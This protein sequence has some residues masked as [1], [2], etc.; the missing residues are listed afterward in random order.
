MIEITDP[1]DPRIEPYRDLRWRE[2]VNGFIAEGPY[3]VER[4]LESSLA[5]R[6]LLFLKGQESRFSHLLPASTPVYTVDRRLGKQIAGYDFHRGVLAHGDVP[7]MLDC[8][9]LRAR[10]PKV[11]LGLIG[12]GDPENVGSL[13]R[14]AAALGV[15]DI[16]MDPTTIPPF[17][18]RVIRVSMASVFQHRF[19]RLD[20]PLAQIAS[21][22]A[23]RFCCAATILT[24]GAIEIN[25][26]HEQVSGVPVVLLLGN[27]G[28][29]LPENVQK[30]CRIRTT[31]PMARSIDSLNVG[32]AGAIFLYEL[33]KMKT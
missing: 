21:L 22:Q 30:Q 19:Y 23:S 29:G 8:D 14:S 24:A 20:E 5:V 7:P 6:S 11:T 32:V 16:L 27:E 18:R 28:D 10:Q 31:L 26:L 33:S 25:R 4:L 9:A 3:V 17:V 13:L 1:S 2:P 15:R 12:V